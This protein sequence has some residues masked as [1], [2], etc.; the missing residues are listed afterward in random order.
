MVTHTLII[1]NKGLHK[2]TEIINDLKNSFSILNIYKFHWEKKYFFDNLKRFYSHSQ[3]LRKERKFNKIIRKKIKH[4]GDGDFTV[5]VFDDLDPK[6]E[7]R[8]TSS[9]TNI[10]NTNVFDKKTKYRKLTEGGHKI[11]SSD[12]AFETNKDLALLFG[13]ST[14]D[15]KNRELLKGDSKISYS[16]NVIGIPQWTHVKD[17]FFVLNNSIEYV[18]LRNFDCLPDDYNVEG[19]GDIDLLVENLSYMIYLTGAKAVYPKRKYRCHYTIAINNEL[20]PFDFRYVEDNY[21]DVKWELDILKTRELKKGTFY[22]PNNENLFYSLLYH[23]L[24]HK[25]KVGEDYKNTLDNLKSLVPNTDYT[26]NE[27]DTGFLNVL[28]KF[29]E[30]MKYNYVVPTD[31]SVYFNNAILNTNPYSEISYNRHKELANISVAKIGTEVIPTE[32][33]KYNGTFIKKAANPVC[34]NEFYFLNKLAD[35]DSFPKVVKFSE[36]AKESEIYIKEIKGI[37]FNDI[38]TNIKFWRKK[39][40]INTVIKSIDIL[41]ILVENKIIH[42]DFRPQNIILEKVN[43]V[44]TPRLIDFGWATQLDDTNPMT[45][46][47]LGDKFK[48]ADDEFSD[49]YSAGMSLKKRLRFFKFPKPLTNYLLSLKPSSYLETDDILRQLHVLKAEYQTHQKFSI[50]DYVLLNVMRIYVVINIAVQQ[51]KS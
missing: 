42:R 32:V 47:G 10:V 50:Q 25:P 39:H 38:Y 26:K 44:F 7:K 6:F 15:F 14:E 43:R 41:I 30:R 4:C 33:Y 22:A 5:I 3:Y 51:I 19:H 49:L 24:I 12:N 16:K 37:S 48:F 29:M 31:T 2:E 17:L 40:I 13:L 45:P 20:V 27:T 11:H 1:W 9:G 21:Y 36:G 23:A 34:L 18:V 35:Y 8:V 46:A 28:T